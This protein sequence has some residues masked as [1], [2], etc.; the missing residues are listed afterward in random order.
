MPAFHLVDGVEESLTLDQELFGTE[1]VHT[2]L[3]ENRKKASADLVEILHQEARK[4][5]AGLDQP[6]DYT[7]II[8]KMTEK[9]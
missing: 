2:L 8:V 9:D 7:T 3:R 5:I 4:H 1:R 6:D